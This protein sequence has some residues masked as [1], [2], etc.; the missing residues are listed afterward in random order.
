MHRNRWIVCEFCLIKFW[1]IDQFKLWGHWKS[2]L[3]SV[4]YQHWK[5]ITS[6]HILS[7]YRHNPIRNDPCCYILTTLVH[8]IVLEERQNSQKLKNVFREKLQIFLC[9]LRQRRFDYSNW[10]NWRASV[11]TEQKFDHVLHIKEYF[12]LSYVLWE[13][14]LFDSIYSKR[15][16]HQNSITIK[17]QILLQFVTKNLDNWNDDDND[18]CFHEWIIKE[19]VV[20]RWIRIVDCNN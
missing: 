16:C 6:C 18:A 15:F 13:M 7:Y 4:K 10:T 20:K 12:V 5:C 3:A 14:K 2:F 9:C 11:Q 8:S 17:C 19:F 1:I